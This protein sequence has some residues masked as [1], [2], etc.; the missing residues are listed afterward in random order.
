MNVSAYSIAD[1]KKMVEAKEIT[2]QDLTD[3]EQDPRKGVRDLVYHIRYQIKKQAAQQAAFEQRLTLE[4]P[5]WQRQE[6]VAGVD[7]VGR[8]PLAGPVVTC[9]VVLAPD[10]DVWGVNDSK[11]LSD[12]KRRQLVPQILEK[13]QSV[14]LGLA[15]NRLIDSINI[16]EATR[17]AMAQA[18]LGLNLKPA[19]LLVD[20]MNVPVALP[21]Q[22]LIKGDAKSASIAAASIVAKVM[23]DDLMQMYDRIYP[24]YALAQN[25]GYGTRAHLAGLAK[26]GPTP[27][28]RFSFSPVAKYQHS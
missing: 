15:D 4:R 20:A 10:F 12:H 11:Q 6:R 21:Q 2:E 3:L 22:R 16:Y 13:A 8:G 28:H 1:L 5:Y 14:S 7:E 9:A 18:V 19:A 17:Q 27:I 23:R 25:M 24:G 26:L